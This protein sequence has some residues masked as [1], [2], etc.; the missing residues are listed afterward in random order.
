MRNLLVSLIIILLMNSNDALPIKKGGKK[1]N[2]QKTSLIIKSPVF[3][4]EE[5]LPVKYSAFV[6]GINPPLN[7]ENVPANTKSLTLLVEDLD[8]P[9]GILDH[10]LV[11]NIPP[12]TKEISEGSRPA[13]SPSGENTVGNLS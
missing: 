2:V 8:A 10:W 4:N 7:F 1:M 12:T 5:Y 9:G 6:E 3:K 13:N 11:F